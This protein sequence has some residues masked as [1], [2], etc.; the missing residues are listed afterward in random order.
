MNHAT[1]GSVI[2]DNWQLSERMAKTIEYHHHPMFSPPEEIPESCL[3]ESFVVC[4]S[5]LICKSIGYAAEDEEHDRW[6]IRP[7]YF[8]LFKL[9]PNLSGV[10]S[11]RLLQDIEAAHV[12]VQSYVAES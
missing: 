5:D 4:L 3:R 12:T 1:L 11:V 7:E 6:Q 2:A 8:E 10:L 9:S